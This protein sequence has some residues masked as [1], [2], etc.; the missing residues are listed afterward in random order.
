MLTSIAPPA[1]M[2]LGGRTV[3]VVEND[4]FVRRLFTGWLTR[5]GARVLAA[6]GGR[7]ALLLLGGERIDAVVADLSMPAPTG[8]DVLREARQLYGSGITLVVVTAY[9]DDDDAMAELAAMAVTR[10]LR[11]PILP[12]ALLGALGAGHDS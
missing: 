4:F 11:K 2:A 5:A 12:P 7:E 6:E 9:D 8:L 1:G 3:L 10:V